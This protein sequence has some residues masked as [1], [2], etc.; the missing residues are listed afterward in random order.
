MVD[1]IA[2]FGLY[3]VS[4]DQ[5]R[6]GSISQKPTSIVTND[7]EAQAVLGHRCNHRHGH[8][9]VYGLAQGG[10]IR[11]NTTSSLSS[12][13]VLGSGPLGNPFSNAE[14]EAA[15]PCPRILAGAVGASL[16]S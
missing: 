4:F 1:W 3:V 5:C 10:G 2:E 15:P 11:H 8:K 13:A 9:G 6:H 14:P 16:P 12:A 7:T